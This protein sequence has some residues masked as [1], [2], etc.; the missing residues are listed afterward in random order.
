MVKQP[1]RPAHDCGSAHLTSG[2]LKLWT[3]IRGRQRVA[4]A[5]FL[6][7]INRWI[8]SDKRFCTKFNERNNNAGIPVEVLR[9][10]QILGCDLFSSL[11][12]LTVSLFPE[13]FFVQT[14]E[15]YCFAPNW[16]L[17]KSMST[18]RKLNKLTQLWFKIGLKHFE[19]I[20][21]FSFK[22]VPRF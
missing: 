6:K 11:N 8:F 16:T 10:D 18:P 17:V 2:P 7:V 5:I 9:S 22:Y 15:K 20:Y 1:A 14:F 3:F 21:E 13:W 12:T 19:H 4:V